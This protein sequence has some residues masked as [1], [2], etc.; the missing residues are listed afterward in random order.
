MIPLHTWQT[1]AAQY[2]LLSTQGKDFRLA[3]LAA[4]SINM[5]GNPHDSRKTTLT[6]FA[7]EAGTTPER[8]QRHLAAWEVLATR[9]ILP[10]PNSLNPA[11]VTRNAG[12]GMV[13]AFMNVYDAAKS[14]GRP[15]ASVTEITTRLNN[16][17][18]YLSKVVGELDPAAKAQVRAA[19]TPKHPIHTADDTADRRP[20]GLAPVVDLTAP[21]F[22]RLNYLRRALVDVQKEAKRVPLT[23]MTK[24]DLYELRALALEVDSAVQSLLTDIGSALLV[25]SEA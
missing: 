9:G 4:C 8:V 24:G 1:N 18:A 10:T 23:Q 22:D 15:R 20:V 13:E 25:K 14:G 3:V 11:S 7:R 5:Q 16:D 6:Q 21:R 12:P 2:R 19:L 17:P